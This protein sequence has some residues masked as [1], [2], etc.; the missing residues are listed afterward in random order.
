MHAIIFNKPGG[1]EVLE[2]VEI[3]T[4]EPGPGQVRI[5]VSRS[6]V[7]PADWKRRAGLLVDIEP[8]V[9]PMK[10]GFET[11]GVVD[12]LGEG[13]TEFAVGDRVFGI[14]TGNN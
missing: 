5:R 6:T 8:Y 3:E 9:Y 13:V 14:R 11:A 10:M 12:K 1:P 7:N 2:Y 4:P